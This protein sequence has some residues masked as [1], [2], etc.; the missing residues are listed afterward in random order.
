V[1]LCDQALR[2]VGFD[3][4]CPGISRAELHTVVDALADYVALNDIT[5]GRGL[6]EGL[7]HERA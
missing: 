5:V 2:Y 1:S 4:R 7:Q 3:E 6:V